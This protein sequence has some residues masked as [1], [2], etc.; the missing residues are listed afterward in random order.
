MRSKQICLPNLTKMRA[1]EEIK[2]HG[3]EIRVITLSL[4][5]ARIPFHAS[6]ENLKLWQGDAAFL[7]T[8]GVRHDH[9]A[10]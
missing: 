7:I 3:A 9:D 5:K 6:E 4:G 8:F 2:Y 1:G 10:A